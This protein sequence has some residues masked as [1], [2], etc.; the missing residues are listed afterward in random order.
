[1]RRQVAR[2]CWG[3]AWAVMINSMGC[4]TIGLAEGD[5]RTN[6]AL[7]LP[8]GIQASKLPDIPSPTLGGSQ[9]WSDK[10]FVH[11]WS[12]QRRIYH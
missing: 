7:D 11:T 9:F 5:E 3:L 10:H 8:G 1:M 12:I 6:S 2:I 4:S